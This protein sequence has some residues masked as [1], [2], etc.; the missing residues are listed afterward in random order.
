MTDI[1]PLMQGDGS[2]ISVWTPVDTGLY[3][4]QQQTNWV[5]V[6][7]RLFQMY[8][9]IYS[10]CLSTDNVKQAKGYYRKV[11]IETS[12]AWLISLLL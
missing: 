1:V 3:K 10:N 11:N 12:D 6:Q 2:R 5:E 8:C 4:F 9:M 7:R